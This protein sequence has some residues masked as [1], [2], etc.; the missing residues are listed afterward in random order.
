VTAVVNRQFGRADANAGLKRQFREELLSSADRAAEAGRSLMA[1]TLTQAGPAPLPATPTAYRVAGSFAD[2][3]G[4]RRV[5]EPLTTSLPANAAR[6]STLLARNG[7]FGT[8][9]HWKAGVCL[10]K[11]SGP[12]NSPMR[13]LLAMTALRL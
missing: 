6:N 11:V 5:Q 9:L 2:A 10:R 3:E 4:L 13:G 8:A 7:G 1:I 12:L